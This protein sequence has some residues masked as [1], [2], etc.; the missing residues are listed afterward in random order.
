MGADQMLT[1]LAQDADIGAFDDVAEAEATRAD[2]DAER[3]HIVQMHRT[4]LQLRER[5]VRHRRTEHELQLL[6]DAAHDLAALRD[7]DEVLQA[8]ADRSRILLDCDLAYISLSDHDRGD[9]YIKAAAGSISAILIGLRLPAGAGLGGL[10]AGTGEPHSVT[11]YLTDQHIRREPE[12]D[13]AVRAEQIESLLGAPV[14]LGRRVIG[15]LLAA[16]RT[17]RQFSDHDITALRML[18]HH[19]AV[20]IESARLLSEA[21][22]AV[23]QLRAAN[24]TIREH[25]DR[26]ERASRVHERLTALVLRGSGIQEV[27]DETAAAMAGEV[28]V[29]DDRQ[30]VLASSDRTDCL[31]GLVALATLA[32]DAGR[33]VNDEN[34]IAVPMITLSGTLGAMIYRGPVTDA[35]GQ[36]LLER[37][38][39]AAALILSTSRRIAEAEERIG[40]ELLTELL[41]GQPSDP[42]TIR[43]RAARLEVDLQSCRL[44]LVAQWDAPLDEVLRT[45][46]SSVARRRHGLAARRG[47]AM[48]LVLPAN[49]PS[50]EA[51]SVAKELRRGQLLVT[52]GYCHARSPEE[53]RAAAQEATRCLHALSS[54]GRIGDVACVGDLGF[55]AT[56]LGARADVPQFV[57]ATLGPLLEYDAAHGTDLLGTLETYAATDRNARESARALHVHANTVT[58]RLNRLGT[59]LGSDWRDPSRFLEIQIAL[60]MHRAS[61]AFTASP[62]PGPSPSPM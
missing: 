46:A 52:A 38:A 35:D 30:D 58:Q 25:L 14:I 29:V 24:V 26:S 21:E 1:L 59:L 9:S 47:D 10:V 51:R 20:A 60:R 56:M 39:L 5:L 57:A 16:H 13:R 27:V 61:T 37:A 7:P 32:C 15:V 2:D 17:V 11:S 49:D 54:L 40:G 48:M 31:D 28:A 3:A 33:A 53:L 34:G 50:A 41:S 6:N 45:L 12:T 23:V 19:A 62:S 42:A 43:H 36:R 18:A 44:V 4:A 8:I 22:A 55:L